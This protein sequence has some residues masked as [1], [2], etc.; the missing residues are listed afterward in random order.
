MNKYYCFA[1][2]FSAK[3]AFTKALGTGIAKG[4]NFNEI[5]VYNIRSG[6]PQVKLQGNTKKIVNKIIKKSK[7]N[8]FLSISDDKPFAVATVVITL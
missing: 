8:I 6:K 2:R 4:I 5:I 1:K 7:F 3:E